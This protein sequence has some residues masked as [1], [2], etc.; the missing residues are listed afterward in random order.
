MSWK[1]DQRLPLRGK[2]VPQTGVK[3][4]WEQQ[5]NL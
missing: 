5:G 3:T 1:N 4:A 2:Y